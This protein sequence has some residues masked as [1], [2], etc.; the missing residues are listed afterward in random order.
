MSY[1]Q[2]YAGKS[3]KSD[4][5]QKEIV[6]ALRR[7]GASVFILDRPVDLLVGVF[8]RTGLIEV[9]MEDGELT[10]SQKKFLK[11]WRGAMIPIVRSIEDCEA[12]IE[13]IKN[14]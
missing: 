11:D 13:A 9:K 7:L 8:G 3:T 2:R 1:R 12:A 6:E 14:Q 10:S 4:K 5:N